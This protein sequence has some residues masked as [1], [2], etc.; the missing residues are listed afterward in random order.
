VFKLNDKLV[1]VNGGGIVGAYDRAPVAVVAESG[2]NLYGRKLS[3]LPYNGALF[4][5][6]CA[7]SSAGPRR[8]RRQRMSVHLCTLL[9]L[10]QRMTPTR[11]GS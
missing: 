8:D 5:V 9:T 6:A 7:R 3:E 11:S 1:I 2:A 10:A 4:N